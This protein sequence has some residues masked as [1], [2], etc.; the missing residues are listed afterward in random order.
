MSGCHVSTF[1]LPPPL[2]SSSSLS[3]TLLFSSLASQRHCWGGGRWGETGKEA[4]AAATWE[5]ARAAAG[6]EWRC[7]ATGGEAAPQ[8]W[9]TRGTAKQASDD[10][11]G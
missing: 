8:R 5:K 4:A 6:R 3:L 2:P 10:G 7:V 1:P 11:V 9:T